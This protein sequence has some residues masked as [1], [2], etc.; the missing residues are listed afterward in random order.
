MQLYID[1]DPGHSITVIEWSFIHSN[2]TGNRF[3]TVL[4]TEL[5]DLFVAK[6]VAYIFIQV[7]SQMF[8]QLQ[9]ISILQVIYKISIYSLHLQFG[10]T[11]NKNIHT[12]T[13]MC[14][15]LVHSNLHLSS[16]VQSSSTSL[17]PFSIYSRL[18]IEWQIQ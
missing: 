8:I 10:V 9:Q 6:Y 15:V 1:Q 11:S 12:Y 13:S 5:E 14:I 17:F 7:H 2:C 3:F 4:K 16:S 18:T